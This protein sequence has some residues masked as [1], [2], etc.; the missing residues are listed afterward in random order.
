MFLIRAVVVAELLADVSPKTKQEWEQ[1][2]KEKSI[3]LD[4]TSPRQ[5]SS[6]VAQLVRAAIDCF[7]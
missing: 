7:P 4:K 2:A 3:P 5:R 6:A 1:W